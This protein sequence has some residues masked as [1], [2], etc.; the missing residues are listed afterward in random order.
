MS[1]VSDH[2]WLC[3]GAEQVNHVNNQTLMELLQLADAATLQDL[4][5]LLKTFYSS[6]KDE[7]LPVIL[8]HD[9]KMD[10][11]VSASFCRNR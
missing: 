7:I 2:L 4:K 8:L 6:I 3:E 9:T 11:R 1:G 10:T 5:V